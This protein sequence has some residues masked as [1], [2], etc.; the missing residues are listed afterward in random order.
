MTIRNVVK[1]FKLNTKEGQVE[2]QPGT[3][4]IQDEHLEHWFVQA[5]LEPLAEKP[6]AKAETEAK[7]E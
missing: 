6:K 5:H 7:K 4:E 2:F 1:A 3:Q